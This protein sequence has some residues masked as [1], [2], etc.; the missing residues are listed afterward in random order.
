MDGWMVKEKGRGSPTA[1]EREKERNG[2]KGGK[3]E[4]EVANGD[5]E[6]EE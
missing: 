3:G 4:R 1:Y 5:W 6:G 2:R